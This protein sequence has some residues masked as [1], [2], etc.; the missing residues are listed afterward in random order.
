MSMAHLLRRVSYGE[1]IVIARAGVPVAKL[2]PYRGE[3][4]REGLFRSHLRVV[5]D[6]E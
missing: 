2:V 4:V 1:E 6:D 3:R 5:S